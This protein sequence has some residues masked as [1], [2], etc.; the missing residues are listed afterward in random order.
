LTNKNKTKNKS[1]IFQTNEDFYERLWHFVLALTA[2]SVQYIKLL[3]DIYQE[4]H[5]YSTIQQWIDQSVLTQ[6]LAEQILS[7][8]TND[9]LLD[10]YYHSKTNTNSSLFVRFILKKRISST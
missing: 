3:Q 2:N 1:N 10:N 9:D 5:F 8:E 6:C 7:L 4:G